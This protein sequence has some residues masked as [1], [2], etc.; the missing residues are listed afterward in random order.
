MSSIIEFPQCKPGSWPEMSLSLSH[1]EIIEH[2]RKI[3][4]L[5]PFPGGVPEVLESMDREE[6]VQ[7]SECITSGDLRANEWLEDTV[8]TSYRGA[9]HSAVQT[10]K[11]LP[12]DMILWVYKREEGWGLHLMKEEEA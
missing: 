11:H 10:G 3:Y 7:L 5:L 8:W 6:I 1:D 4:R 2:C 9:I 12:E